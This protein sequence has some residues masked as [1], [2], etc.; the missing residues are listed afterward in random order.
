MNKLLCLFVLLLPICA[1]GDTF[2]Y[3]IAPTQGKEIQFELQKFQTL[4][5]FQVKPITCTLSTKYK[6]NVESLIQTDPYNFKPII[7][8]DVNVSNGHPYTVL[9]HGEST[10]PYPYFSVINERGCN[11]AQDGAKCREAKE[12]HLDNITVNCTESDD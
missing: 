1:F 9:L 8:K 12:Q 10:N 3:T 5:K 2:E 11:V 6:G 7:T 4:N